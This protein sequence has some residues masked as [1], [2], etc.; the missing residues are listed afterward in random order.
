MVLVIVWVGYPEVWVGI[1]GSLGGY[2]F[3]EYPRKKI[4]IAYI[5]NDG[6]QGGTVLPKR[7]IL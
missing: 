6:E 1:P 3:W 2:P 4:L 7:E 5:R